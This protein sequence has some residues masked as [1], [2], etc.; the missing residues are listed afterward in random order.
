M[1]AQEAQR[2]DKIDF[3][4]IVVQNHLHFPVAKAFLEAGFHVICDKPMTHYYE[5]ALELARDR[6]E[7][8]TASLR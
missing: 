7:E 2:E 5:L 3:V 4:S 6:E 1:A 8:R